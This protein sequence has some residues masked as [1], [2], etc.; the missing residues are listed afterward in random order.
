[1]IFQRHETAVLRRVLVL[2]Y[3]TMIVIEI[4]FLP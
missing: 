4:R 2:T 3:K 1:M